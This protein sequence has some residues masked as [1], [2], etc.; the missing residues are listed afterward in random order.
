M[1][2]F[3]GLVWIPGKV[4]VKRREGQYDRTRW[5]MVGKRGGSN[6]G[7]SGA[8]CSE[9]RRHHISIR[10]WRH[11]IEKGLRTVTSKGKNRWGRGTEW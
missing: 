6:Q 1:F 4:C 10:G 7:A 11:R 5:A 2:F 3:G 9:K 8:A